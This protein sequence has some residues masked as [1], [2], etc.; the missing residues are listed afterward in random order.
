MINVVVSQ[1]ILLA[2]VILRGYGRKH[3]SPRCAIQMDL[4][5]EHDTVEWDALEMIMQELNFPG[6]FI[7]WIMVCGTSVS[8]RY[9]IINGHHSRLLKTKRGLRLETGRSYISSTCCANNGIP[10]QMS[11]TTQIAT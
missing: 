8:Y 7:C 1:S 11:A 4:Q 5:K 9:S 2:H 6:Q 10:S 3:L